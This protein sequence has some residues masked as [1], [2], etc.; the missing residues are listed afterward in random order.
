M[1]FKQIIVGLLLAG[2]ILSVAPLLCVSEDW[3]FNVQPVQP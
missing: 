3:N 2:E 1:I